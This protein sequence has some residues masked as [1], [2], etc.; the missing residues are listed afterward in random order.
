LMICNEA[1]KSR[2]SQT[3]PVGTLANS[4]T[5]NPNCRWHHGNWDFSRMS[6]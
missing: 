6:L 5:R 4:P 1:A 2:L 3:A